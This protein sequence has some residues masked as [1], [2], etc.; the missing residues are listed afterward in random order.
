M[1]ELFRDR[2]QLKGKNLV[3]LIMTGNILAGEN[4]NMVKFPKNRQI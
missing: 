3:C 1:I 4:E 2:E